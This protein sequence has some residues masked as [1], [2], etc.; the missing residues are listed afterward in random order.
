MGGWQPQ[1]DTT[2]TFCPSVWTQALALLLVVQIS[3][4]M[5]IRT[6]LLDCKVASGVGAVGYSWMLG[7]GGAGFLGKR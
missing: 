3:Q 2:Y 4:E 1:R 7:L 5:L 6:N